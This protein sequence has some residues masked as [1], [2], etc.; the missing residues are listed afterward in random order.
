[1]VSVASGAA[2]CM[3][4]LTFSRTAWIFSGKV[5]MY[6]SIVAKRFLSF[7]CLSPFG[8]STS[9]PAR[10][11]HTPTS[12]WRG[13]TACRPIHQIQALLLAVASVHAEADGRHIPERIE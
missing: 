6:S 2:L 1:M 12:S 4:C 10:Q 3:V 11:L 5:E 13:Q 7:I 8:L 9:S